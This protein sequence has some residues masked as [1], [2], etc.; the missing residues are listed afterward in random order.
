MHILAVN[1]LTIIGVMYENQN[2]PRETR[3]AGNVRRLS[4][5]RSVRRAVRWP[6]HWRVALFYQPVLRQQME[7]PKK[8]LRR[9]S[10]G[11]FAKEPPPNFT[12]EQLAQALAEFQEKSKGKQK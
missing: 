10:K 4:Q 7:K 11:K 8:P 5:Y 3:Q 12:P 6:D 9:D 2:V 1:P